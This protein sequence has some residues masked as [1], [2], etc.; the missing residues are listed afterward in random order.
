MLEFHRNRFHETLNLHVGKWTF[1]RM[2]SFDSVTFYGRL[3]FPSPEQVIKIP[4]DPNVL[5]LVPF[6]KQSPDVAKRSRIR[7][8]AKFKQ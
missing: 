5:Q 8:P 6:T 3:N 2:K 7:K 1:F 4:L